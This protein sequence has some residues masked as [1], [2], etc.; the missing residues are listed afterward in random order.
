M[1]IDNQSLPTPGKYIGSKMVMIALAIMTFAGLVRADWIL[2]DFEKPVAGYAGGVE[3]WAYTS[4]GSSTA[5]ANLARTTSTLGTTG[6]SLRFSYIV[7]GAIGTYPGAGFGIS[8]PQYQQVNIKGDSLSFVVNGTRPASITAVRVSFS[9]QYGIGDTTFDSVRNAGADFGIQIETQLNGTVKTVK[10]PVSQMLLPSWLSS[11]GSVVN[12][13]NARQQAFGRWALAHRDSILAH[14]VSFAVWVNGGATV[15]ASSGTSSGSIEFDDFKLL[16]TNQPAPTVSNGFT[17]GKVALGTPDT[18]IYLPNN[19]L[20]GTSYTATVLNASTR[21]VAT[22]TGDSL[23][24]HYNGVAGDTDS[25]VVSATNGTGTVSD[26][27]RVTFPT[28]RMVKAIP[29]DTLG[30]DQAS[31]PAIDLSSYLEETQSNPLAFQATSSDTNHVKVSLVGATLR[32]SLV[33][34]S[35][36]TATIT[37]RAD[38]GADTAIT[39]FPVVV[40]PAYDAP[41]AVNPLADITVLENALTVAPVGIGGIFASPDHLALAYSIVNGNPDVASATLVGNNINFVV[42]PYSSGTDTVVVKADDGISQ[43]TSK[44]VLVVT[45]VPH[46]EWLINDFNTPSAYGNGFEGFAM[47]GVG[48]GGPAAVS[49]AVLGPSTIGTGNSLHYSWVVDGDAYPGAGVQALF[50]AKKEIDVR[51]DTLTFRLKGTK[52]TAITNARFTIQSSYGI[53]DTTADSAANAGADFGVQ[54]E[55]SF[56]A[57]SHS[58]RIPVSSMVLPNWLSS[59]G[60]TIGGGDARQK[61]YGRWAVAH[62]DSILAHAIGLHVWFGGAEY[63][64]GSPSRSG[65]TMELDDLKLQGVAQPAPQILKPLSD[66]KI[67]LG[68]P[69]YRLG[70]RAAVFNDLPFLYATSYTATKTAGSSHVTPTI[71]GDSLVLALN[72]VGGAVDT[73]IATA[74]NA[75]GSVSDTFLVKFSTIRQEKAFP[76]DTLAEDQPS[77]K[78]IDLSTYFTETVGKTIQYSAISLDTHRVRTSVVGSN[79]QLVLAPDSNGQ[80]WI[81]VQAS[82]GTDTAETGFLAVLVP[83]YDAPRVLHP[84][85]NDSVWEDA[86]TVAPVSIA[87]LFQSPDGLPLTYSVSHSAPSK[88]YVDINGT[89]IEISLTRYQR[90]IDTITV[91]ADDGISTDTSRFLLVIKP[92]NHA[93]TVY[94]T[95][96]QQSTKKNA[97]LLLNLAG[98]F[99]D[100][101]GDKL[102]YTVA[103]QNTSMLSATVK[104]SIATLVPQSLASGATS[105]S[106]TAADSTGAF[107]TT[108]QIT[109]IIRPSANDAP[110]SVQG[111]ADLASKEDSL[112]GGISVVGHFSDLNLADHLHYAARSLDTTRIKVS[113]DSS[114][115]T[116]TLVRFVLQPNATGL[117]SIVVTAID[118][119]GATASAKFAVTLAPA[120]DAPVLAVAFDTLKV[121]EDAAIAAIRLNAHFKDID[122]DKLAYKVVGSNGTVA[123]STIVSDSLLSLVLVANA[124]GPDTITLTAKDPSLDS[125]VTKFVLLVA[126]AN[127]A[128]V[129]KVAFAQLDTKEDSTLGDLSLAGHFGDIDLG[130][131]LRYSVRSS[132]TTKLK[133]SLVGVGADTAIR[134]QLQ[135]DANG[136]DTVAV[137]AIDDSGATVRTSFV[138]RIA[139]VNDRPAVASPFADISVKEDSS[140]A[141]IDLKPH[142]RDIDRDVLRYSV[143]GSD[144]SLATTT[145]IGDTLLSIA[146]VANRSGTDTLTVLAIDPS[147][148]SIATKFVVK[149]ASVLDAPVLKAPFATIRTKEDS[150]IGNLSLAGRFSDPDLGDHLR[151]AVKSL[152]TTK[153]KVALETSAS[154]TVVKFTLVPDAWGLDTVLVTATDDSGLTSTSKVAIE[155]ASVN[156][157]PVARDTTLFSGADSVDVVPTG[158][159]IDGTIAGWQVVGSP[160]HGSASIKAGHLVYKPNL[161]FSGLDTVSVVAIDAD[162]GRSNP[163]KVIFSIQGSTALRVRTLPRNTSIGVVPSKVL[164]PPAVGTGIGGLGFQVPSCDED[165]NCEAVKILLSQ[166][167]R[168][169][170]EIH[171]NLG[172]GVIRW[173]GSLDKRDLASLTTTDDGRK[174]A[175]VRWNLRSANGQPAANGVYLWKVRVVADDGTESVTYHRLGVKG[176]LP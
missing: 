156:D 160:N 6:Q 161:A 27:F 7:D 95:I 52:G 112:L 154:D 94:A 68:Y 1:I 144:P 111:F 157:L 28:I 80:T 15:Y 104:D 102:V 51:G 131:H 158:K 118:D 73:V 162:S 64:S 143:R 141:A 26:T 58:I 8:I 90:G 92:V 169:S 18:R 127:D 122:A 151:Y 47:L 72:T 87:G 166:P 76:N 5:A 164:L 59:N 54:L 30:E 108:S 145:V 119:S 57:A 101:D 50:Q 29:A 152:D 12:G 48:S 77:I 107:A 38:N 168:V 165:A 25:V 16:G 128:P 56:D 43:T 75:T 62:R 60:T 21:V 88:A 126:P 132:D 81:R 85:A 67:P 41:R 31:I 134:F 136:T 4:A 20:N 135:P 172:S 115:A 45:A 150:S 14:V 149:V 175:T 37:V 155:I 138:V 61:A 89:D 174:V 148:D 171:D 105:F 2:Q 109:L 78:T 116:D 83:Q 40:V 176:T 84:I 91:V 86:A 113:I 159:D 24:V 142:F 32:L 96:P 63:V 36:G 139:S 74:T 120:N 121:R 65:G 146:L 44:V 10:I 23:L 13:G 22:V 55:S 133:V 3:G 153:V 170:V 19:F 70:L 114:S 173:T 53:G 46:K 49:N 140:L 39:T 130:D 129:A 17:D 99:R 93:P 34:D 97:K 33:P 163:A 35:N 42:A 125:V 9:S 69:S 66:L 98:Y 124:S 137:T 106:V 103:P 82:N 147:G 110:I 123:T 167:A 117:D 100:V 79:L 11:N 71:V